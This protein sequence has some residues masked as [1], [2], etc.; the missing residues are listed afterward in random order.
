[1]QDIRQI[2]ALPEGRTLEFKQDLSSMKPILKTLIAFANTAG[3]TLI[4]GRTDDGTIKGIE[5]ILSAEEKLANVIADNIHPPLLPEIEMASLDGR[6][7]IV[8][9]IPHWRGPFYLKSKGEAEGVYV[10]LGSTNRVAGPELLAE[11]K[12]SIMKVS[13]DQLPC[14]E[15]NISGLDMDQIDNEFS[16]SG[17]QVNQALLETLNIL[18]PYN[19]GVVCSNGGLILFGKQSVR[20]QYFPNTE[21][22]CA[23]FQGQEKANFIDRYDVQGSI[24]EAMRDVPKFIMR[25]TRLAAQ[26]EKIRRKDIS[27]YSLVVIREIL[28][29]ALVH[30]DYS[31]IGM[32]PRIAIFSDRLEIDSPGMLP[33]GY[34][35]S[36]FFAG[37]SHIRNKVIARVFRELNIIEEWGTGY[38]RI[39]ETCRAESYPIPVWQEHGASLRVILK[40]HG[41]TVERSGIKI[42]QT[43]QPFTS[44]QEK[45]MLFLASGSTFATKEI[46]KGLDVQVSERTLR[47]DL[48]DMKERGLIQMFG[49]G[50][51]TRWGKL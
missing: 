27:E 26:I 47:S 1:M 16:K 6:S 10:R 30:A 51:S 39:N 19:G 11:L 3:G 36:D 33:Y 18:V 40:P 17:R 2:I 12:R 34:A 22:R 4:I 28:A 9:R 24:L 8:V 23:R 14:P 21:V 43:E 31:I 38:R 13:F 15:V 45:I 41:A 48:R 29:N 44:R 46:L 37:V 5:D 35:L 25:N 50:P 20:K 42:S 32:N 49:R 7:L